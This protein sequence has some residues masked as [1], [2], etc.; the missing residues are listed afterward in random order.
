MIEPALTRTGTTCAEKP[1]SLR[2]LAGMRE[3]DVRRV[4]PLLPGGALLRRPEMAAR[5]HQGRGVAWLGVVGEVPGYLEVELRHDAVVGRA[6]ELLLVVVVP[7]G[8]EARRVRVRV[9]LRHGPDRL[10]HLD[11]PARAVDDERQ[12]ARVLHQPAD[13]LAD[14]EGAA[15]AAA[16]LHALDDPRELL[17]LQELL[18]HAELW[19]TRE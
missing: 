17:A 10:A 6:H 5:N 8:G 4:E 19:C 13:R 7:A 16:A 1:V 3:T 14:G 12:H 18:D 9:R 11:V 15:P 2:K